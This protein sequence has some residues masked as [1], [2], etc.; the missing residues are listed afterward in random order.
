MENPLPVFLGDN[1]V[2]FARVEP[3]SKEEQMDL[4][5]YQIG[6]GS[7]LFTVPV[8]RFPETL[9]APTKLYLAASIN[10]WGKAIGMSEWEMKRQE[11]DGSERF[12][13]NV[14]L[15]ELAGKTRFSFKFVTGDRQWLEVSE[16]SPNRETI[17]PGRYNLL[18]ASC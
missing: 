8:A 2:P 7:A 5:G 1:H 14:P 12:T 4:T 16:A 15:A 13:L 11:L 17:E 18:F 6:E 9:E 10:G 3:I